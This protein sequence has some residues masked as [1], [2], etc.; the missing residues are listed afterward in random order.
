LS[1]SGE[2]YNWPVMVS[3]VPTSAIATVVLK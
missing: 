3:V 1:G 2:R